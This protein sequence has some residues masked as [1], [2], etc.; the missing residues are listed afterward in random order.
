MVYGMKFLNE[1]VLKITEQDA[2]DYSEI[3]SEAVV[4]YIESFD[5]TEE[6]LGEGANLDYR[7]AFKKAKREFKDAAKACK[8]ALKDKNKSEAKKQITKMN[9]ALDECEKTINS[10]DS[11]VGSAVLGYFAGSLLHTVE[12]FLPCFIYSFSYGIGISLQQA[13]SMI[14]DINLMNKS[15]AP[16]G[17]SVVAGIIATVKN[18]MAIIK[19]I[20][21]FI[22]DIKNADVSTT[23]AL[24]L[25][26]NKL[27]TYISDFRSS[28]KKYEKLVDKLDI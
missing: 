20:K 26:R 17:V 3:M 4:V 10:I 27:L 18:I 11:T 21:Q 8:R 6:V 25:Y 19:A 2:K 22:D 23:S 7:D 13:G 1:T 12:M 14:N 16:L 15:L 9:K 5:E 28:I 24:N